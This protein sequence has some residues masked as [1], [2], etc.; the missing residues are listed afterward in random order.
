MLHRIEAEI[1]CAC[2]LFIAFI[3]LLLTFTGQAH[4]S[5]LIFTML[6]IEILVVPRRISKVIEILIERKSSIV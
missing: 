4:K 5:I 1:V 2:R 3:F 6:L